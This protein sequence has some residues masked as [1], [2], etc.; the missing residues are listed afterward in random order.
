LPGPIQQSL[1]MVDSDDLSGFLQVIQLTMSNKI[2]DLNGLG[3][4][5][6]GLFLFA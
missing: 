1:A 4:A 6:H 5:L 2:A 3:T